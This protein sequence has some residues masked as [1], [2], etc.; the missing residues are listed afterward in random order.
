[1][2]GNKIR[3]DILPNWGGVGADKNNCDFVFIF[4]FNNFA[5]LKC[6]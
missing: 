3:Y 4:Y 1:M 5:H 2:L 6:Q